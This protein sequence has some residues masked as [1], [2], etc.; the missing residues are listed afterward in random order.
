MSQLKLQFS[1][2]KLFVEGENYL[3]DRERE[4]FLEQ[5]NNKD[6][7][8]GIVERLLKV[9]APADDEPE[10]DDEEPEGSLCQKRSIQTGCISPERLKKAR[11]A[12]TL[13]KLLSLFDEI[14][15]PLDT[16]GAVTMVCCYVTPTT[17]RFVM[18]DCWDCAVM[19]DQTTNKGGYFK[20]QGRQHVLNDI[21]PHIVPEWQE[22]IVN[23]TFVETIDGEQVEYADPM[24]LPSATDVLGRAETDWWKDQDDDFQLPIFQRER[25][26]VKEC[27]ENGTYLWWLR[28]VCASSSSFCYVYTGGSGAATLPVPRV[29]SRRALT[30]NRTSNKSPGRKPRRG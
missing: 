26:R 3:I 15:V 18:K 30:S 1:D 28:S 24:W 17:A 27:G 7:A 19:D 12:G 14:D 2:A 22:I 21:Y 23:R 5:L 8:E 25:D 9:I 10:E 13:D 16:G 6:R 29:V 20:S 11:E 4:A